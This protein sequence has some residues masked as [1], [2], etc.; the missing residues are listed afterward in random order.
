MQINGSEKIAIFPLYDHQIDVLKNSLYG[1]G[2]LGHLVLMGLSILL[3][4]ALCLVPI[5][6]TS[7]AGGAFGAIS[8]VF[9]ILGIF[10]AIFAS[11]CSGVF[12]W[13]VKE[14]KL[15]SALKRLWISSH[16]MFVG[17]IIIS[18]IVVRLTL[19]H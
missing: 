11:I 10:G 5:T 3:A 12:F 1:L 8:F 2:V 16:L 15:R 17:V 18:E 6:E 14:S 4:G 9:L 13:R 7:V 19:S